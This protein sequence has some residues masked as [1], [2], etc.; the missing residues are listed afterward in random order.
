MQG[1]YVILSSVAYPD[2]IF[3]HHLINGMIKKK[4]LLDITCDFLLSIQI[5]CEKFPILRRTELDTM[6]I[7]IGP[8]VK[9]PLFL[10]DFDEAGNFSTDF[11]KILKY[12]I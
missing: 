12:Q 7:Y 1:A 8:H 4:K 10:L 9:C 11:R 5:L 3:P 6:N 2:N